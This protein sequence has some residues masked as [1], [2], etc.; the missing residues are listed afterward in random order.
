MLFIVVTVY[1]DFREC[2]PLFLPKITPV[3]DVFGLSGVDL[4]A[5]DFLGDRVGVTP[6]LADLDLDSFH[7]GISLH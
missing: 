4:L 5:V 2:Q 6:T 1:L 3:G 7:C